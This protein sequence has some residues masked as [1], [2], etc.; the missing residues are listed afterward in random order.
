MCDSSL[1]KAYALITAVCGI[2][3]VCYYDSVYYPVPTGLRVQ[4]TNLSDPSLN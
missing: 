3:Y 1:E 2:V 4:G